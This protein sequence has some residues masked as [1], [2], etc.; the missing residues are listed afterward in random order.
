MA[1]TVYTSKDNQ[2]REYVNGGRRRLDGARNCHRQCSIGASR[3]WRKGLTFASQGRGKHI[4][5]FASNASSGRKAK[6]LPQTRSDRHAQG[7]GVLG[8]IPGGRFARIPKGDR[9]DVELK[10]RRAQHIQHRFR[11]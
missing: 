11:G 4:G 5:R 3:H 10:Q 1:L 2:W 8:V 7:A 9:I 6:V